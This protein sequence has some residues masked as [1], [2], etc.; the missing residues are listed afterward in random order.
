MNLTGLGLVKST[1]VTA[2]RAGL[3]AA[4]LF[5]AEPKSAELEMATLATFP[6]IDGSVNGGPGEKTS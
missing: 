6:L 1:G 3:A 4:G 5:D 2:C